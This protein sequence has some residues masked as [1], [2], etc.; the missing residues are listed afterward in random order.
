MV[1]KNRLMKNTV[2]LAL[3]LTGL[4]LSAQIDD[5]IYNVIQINGNIFNV[6]QSAQLLQGNSFEAGDR[7]NFNQNSFAYVISNYRKKYML[8]TPNIE[9]GDA[10]IFSNAKL[11][12]SPIRSRGQLS[13]RGAVSETGVKDFKTYLGVENFNIIGDRLE[14][15]LDKNRYPLNGEEFIVFYY[16]ING[17]KISKKVGFQNQV[18]KIEKEKLQI[19]KVDTLH[20]DTIPSLSVYKYMQS[21]GNSELITEINLSFLNPIK[22]KKE[23]EIINPILKNQNMTSKEIKEYFEQYII[24]IYGNIDDN[25]L[26]A[27][28]ETIEV[29]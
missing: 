21:T 13:T 5:N 6:T 7:L 2:L 12:L 27:F 3:V 11:A 22:L 14:I 15:L 16:T 19:S 1:K 23:L 9:S 28:I 20:A 24:D 25:Q 18:L 26:S 29:N 4:Q 8:R 10:D 17:K